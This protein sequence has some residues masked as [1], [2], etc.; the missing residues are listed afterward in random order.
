MFDPLKRFLLDPRSKKILYFVAGCIG[1]FLLL[2]L[3]VYFKNGQSESVLTIGE[4]QK[5][6]SLASLSFDIFVK[7]ALIIGII[8]LIFYIYRW[9][10]TKNSIIRKNRL[11][12]KESV[13]FSP[14][15]AVHILRVDNKEFLIGAT[16]QQ[17][18]L[19]SVIDADGNLDG[20]MDSAGGQMEQGEFE[21]V[22][23][24]SINNPFDT[25][26]GDKKNV[27]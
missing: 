8:Y 15:Q 5:E 20:L 17:I 21:S 14:K 10:Q 11:S 6:V 23:Q 13:R 7:L 12:I 24:E 22:L 27:K 25:V 16:D 9:W 18:S 26:K 1:L 3:I 2:L 19:L 4:S